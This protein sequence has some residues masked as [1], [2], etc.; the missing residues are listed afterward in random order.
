MGVRRAKRVVVPVRD[1]ARVRVEDG[2]A[3]RLGRHVRHSIN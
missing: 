3:G 2:L 1:A